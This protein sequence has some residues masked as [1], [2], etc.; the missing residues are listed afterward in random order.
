MK[1]GA[2]SVM[3]FALGCALWAFDEP[4]DE[5]VSYAE[6]YVSRG[7]ELLTRG[8]IAE[9]R[10]SA[11]QACLYDP[12]SSDALFLYALTISQDGP[13]SNVALA[14][15]NLALQKDHFKRFQR[16][17]CQRFVATALERRGLWARALSL[18]GYAERR[19]LLD[20]S[21]A[22]LAMRCLY[23]TGSD[24]YIDFAIAC[25]RRFKSDARFA[26]F[27]LERLDPALRTEQYA[28]L[29]DECLATL[30]VTGYEDPMVW[31]LAAPFIS[32]AARREAAIRAHRALSAGPTA[33]GAC[34]SVEYGLI[35]ETAAVEE[36][37][38][39]GNTVSAALLFRF[40]HALSREEARDSFGKHLRRFTGMVLADDDADD[41]P[42]R[43]ARFENGSL[44]EW[45]Y[46]PHHD[47]IPSVVA[48]YS[49][50]RCI[51][52]TIRGPFLDDG[53]TIGAD[54]PS[55]PYPPFL[56]NIDPAS[57]TSSI[58]IEYDPYPYIG[59]VSKRRFGG[60][61]VVYEMPSRSY[62]LQIAADD[63][64]L[65]DYPVAIPRALDFPL[66]TDRALWGAAFRVTAYSGDGAWLADAELHDGIPILR[67]ERRGQKGLSR[68]FYSNGFPAE[69]YIDSDGD[70]R[71]ETRVSWRRDG[72][73]SYRSRIELD[74]DGD[75]RAEYAES[76]G[77]AT[78][79]YWDYDGDGRFDAVMRT[80]PDGAREFLFSS[81]FD[82]MYDSVIM[83]WLDG[84]IE[85]IRIT[86]F[87]SELTL[88]PDNAPRVF[89]IGLK[90]FDIGTQ[91]LTEGLIVL[92]GPDGKGYAVRVIKFEGNWYIEAYR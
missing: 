58:D 71:E 73:M 88:T 51:R 38:A 79:R 87:G 26:R 32:D 42:E 75:G 60:G 10:A 49:G 24:S 70:G 8:F 31:A 27:A 84:A 83:A 29:L 9:A 46:D 66:P 20:A 25:I 85:K 41:R 39:A 89:W 11:A 16:K 55:L 3:F 57:L 50:G 34:L 1:A 56:T 92:T 67:R 7:L 80:L 44:I 77:E 90:L 65:G 78:E 35:D 6:A 19:A 22:L 4:L 52:A 64:Q 18:S 62:A 12:A 54:T 72:P 53:F 48:V 37:F 61:K 81:A 40:A 13:E 86:R 23:F 45:T 74:A 14:A 43:C 2:V 15:G 17:E 47:G 68:L 30:D 5:S 59:S 36:F 21:D 33:L 91:R 69:E 76:Y 28:P 63:R 82:G